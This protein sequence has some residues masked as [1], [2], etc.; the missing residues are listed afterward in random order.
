MKQNHRSAAF[1]SN[2]HFNHAQAV[3]NIKT[4]RFIGFIHVHVVVPVFLLHM[5]RCCQNSDTLELE[6][7]VP[8][9]PTLSLEEQRVLLSTEHLFSP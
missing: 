3:K 6:L 8:G 9:N 1:I 4:F 5:C 2:K 7:Q